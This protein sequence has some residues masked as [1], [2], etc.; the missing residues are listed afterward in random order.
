[1]RN[2]KICLSRLLKKKK[3]CFE[4]EP[5]KIAILWDKMVDYM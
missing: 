4:V 2:F 1:M 3:K 5:Y